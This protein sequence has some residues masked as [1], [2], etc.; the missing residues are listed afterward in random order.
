MNEKTA[1]MNAA[2]KYAAKGLVDKAIAEWQ[3]LLGDRKDGNI[4]NTIGDLYL[5][6]GSEQ[7]AVEAFTKAAEIYRKDG[8]YP[9]AIAIYKKVLN[10]VP[11][12]VD[13]LIASAKLNANRGLFGNAI[14]N[15]YRAAEIYNKEGSAEK[16]SMVVE[17]I[18]QLEPSDVNTRSKIAYLYFRI[19]LKE[20]AGNEYSSIAHDYLNK[21][22][23][24][25]A[26][27]YFNKALEYAPAGTKASTGLSAL[28]Q[29][30]GDIDQ[31][32]TYLDSAL[33]V[34]PGNLEVLLA[35]SR[36]AVDSGRQDDA[37]RS[38]AILTEMDPSN[39]EAK[40]LLAAFFIK[41]GLYENAWE[42]LEPLINDAVDAEQWSEAQDMVHYFKGH[43]SISIKQCALR[44]S[45]AQGDSLSI[46]NALRELAVLY[47]NEGSSESA[48]QLYK[49][50]L[51]ISPDDAAAVDKVRELETALG[52][53]QPVMEASPE[54]HGTIPEEHVNTL[55]EY[56]E[57]S[58]PE[59][60]ATPEVHIQKTD[61]PASYDEFD[62]QAISPSVPLAD[63]HPVMT[64]KNV[65]DSPR[66]RNGRNFRTSRGDDVRRRI[67]C[68]ES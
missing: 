45:K 48:L 14:D 30:E 35:Y 42:E 61:I 31:A 37:K 43:D 51:D 38:L 56:N 19:G 32:F 64:D 27:E 46:T 33:S 10:I 59:S 34:D 23:H 39:R 11:N 67:C 44:I 55:P 47:E 8:F 62:I 13:A 40:K 36:L 52:I 21:N 20:R 66:G 58:F 5:R 50:L 65:T 7:E 6:K 17:K 9:K 18:L 29:K 22:D 26:R 25:K 1:I 24:E 3:K 4:Q 2:Q 60:E 63:E 53:E 41:E 57:I 49:E 16:A 12:D 68:N 15:Y 28:A 54:V